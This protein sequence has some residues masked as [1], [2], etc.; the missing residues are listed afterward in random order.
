VDEHLL[1]AMEHRLARDRA[2]F[3]QGK[4]LSED[5]FGTIKRAMDQ[6]YF[7]LKGPVQSPRVLHDLSAG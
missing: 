3:A 7:L 5:P 4:A 1:K 6:G 2:L